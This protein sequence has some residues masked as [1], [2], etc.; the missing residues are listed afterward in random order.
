M[1]RD[2]S[3][4]RILRRSGVFNA[5]VKPKHSVL[6]VLLAC[7][8]LGPAAGAE[9]K[10]IEIGQTTDVATPS[11]PKTCN[12]VSRTTGYQA[13]IGP[14]RGLF[15]VPQ[16]GRIVAWTITLSKP[17]PSQIKFFQDNLGG[18]AS[19]GISLL[20]PG[21]HLFSRTLSSSPVHTLTPF[22]G[23]TVQFALT[24]TLVAH[25]GD[26]VALNV[27]TWAPA[28]AVGLGGD[29][30]WRASRPDSGCRDT[31]TQTAQQAGQLTQYR[32]L[33]RTARLLYSATLVTAPGT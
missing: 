18:E 12:A 10:I 9:A 13:K 22:F 2:E 32:C 6:A 20:R 26:V 29:T 1:A 30:S 8:L 24:K 27:P 3:R 15:A 4:D 11:C 25:K 17:G 19:A 33:Y 14:K 7:A 23:K 5:P 31:Q 16:D 28:L 21:A